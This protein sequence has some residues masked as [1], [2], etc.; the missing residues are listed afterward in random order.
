MQPLW[1][2][3]GR[4]NG[5]RCQLRVAGVRAALTLVVSAGPAG[6]R[7]T[8]LCRGWWVCFHICHPSIPRGQVLRPVPAC[9]WRDAWSPCC[10]QAV[11]G[12]ACQPTPRLYVPLLLSHKLSKTI[13]YSMSVNA[14]HVRAGYPGHLPGGRPGS[15]VY[16]C[17][18]R[19]Q[20]TDGSHSAVVA[21]AGMQAPVCC[22]YYSSVG[23]W[24]WCGHK[25]PHALNA[26]PCP[27]GD[28]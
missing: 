25:W 3:G 8:W 26:R 17:S 22:R 28:I 20:Q 5:W 11:C 12:R 10:L 2:R 19:A 1:P 15:A 14:R 4:P 21:D 13:F 9:V 23:A 18:T 7:L 6:S 16:A 24:S 27:Q